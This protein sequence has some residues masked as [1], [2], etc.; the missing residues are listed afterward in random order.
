MRFRLNIGVKLFVGVAFFIITAL[1]IGVIEVANIHRINKNITDTVEEFNKATADDPDKILD[2]IKNYII[3]QEK[4][5]DTSIS[6]FVTSTALLCLMII[7]VGIVGG[8]YFLRYVVLIPVEK[9]ME[10]TRHVAE[11]NLSQRVNIDSHDEIGGLAAALNKMVQSLKEKAASVEGLNKE[12][13]TRKALQENLDKETKKALENEERAKKSL[14][15]QTRIRAANVSMLESLMLS[16]GILEKQKKELEGS[17]MA[18]MN[19]MDDVKQEKAKAEELRNQAESASK[20]KSE[21]LANM[22]H[23]IRTPMNA[24]LGFATLLSGTPLNQQQKDYVDTV[25][26]SGKALLDIINDIL[27]ISKVEAGQ[28]NLEKID[29]D[30][31]Y[32]TKDVFKMIRPR[33]GKKQIELNFNIDRDVPTNLEGDP[34][35]LRQVFINLLGNAV[36]FTQSEEVRLDVRLEKKLDNEMVLL[37]FIVKDTG[38]GIA[39]DKREGIFDAFSQADMSTTRKYGGTGLGLSICRHIV[40]FM[41]GT[42]WVESEIGKGSEFFFTAKFKERPYAAVKKIYPI[43]EDELKDKKALIVDDVDEHQR[44]MGAICAEFGVHSLTASSGIEALDCLSKIQNKEELPDLMLINISMLEMDGHELAKKIR[45]DS[46]C[47]RIKLVAVVTNALAG[48]A[49]KTRDSGFDGFLP[50]PI[51]KEELISLMRTVLGDK[52]EDGQIVTR[53]MAGELSC[54][55][56]RVLV[57]EDIEANQM[58]IEEV[59]KSAGCECDLANNGKEAVEK[60]RANKYDV[61]LM[62]LQMPVMGGIEATQIIH[63][64][65]DKNLPIIALTAAAMNE[66]QKNALAAGMNDFIIKPIDIPLLKEKL[67]KWGRG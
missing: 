40:T 1:A 5:V 56:L 32:L 37:C 6:R 16:K 21:F 34:T 31:E 23:E 60:A 41:K 25:A 26:S 51:I 58:L 45:K 54:K 7:M 61:V 10:F 36:K 39:D 62:D 3:A 46:S 24:I 55:D 57:A 35:R 4:E 52:R 38:M 66:D 64:D 11:G 17:R 22:S 13:E 9:M 65:I 53:H 63:R 18:I 14:N 48:D 67:V 2:N 47:D 8:F 50:R 27:D 33:V 29:F 28:I 42:I 30:L 15:E 19:M 44:L 43:S 12:V 59:L 20:T 49:K